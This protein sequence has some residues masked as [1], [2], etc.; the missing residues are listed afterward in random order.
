MKNNR[1]R[2]NAVL[3][4]VVFIVSILTSV[5]FIYN[6][7]NVSGKTLKNG[8]TLQIDKNSGISNESYTIGNNPTELLRENFKELTA[9]LKEEDPIKISEYVA[10]CFVIDYYTWTNKDGN[11]EVGGLQYIYGS[12]FSNFYDESRHNFYG[13][14]DLLISKYGHENLLEV[15]SISG[16]GVDGGYYEVNGQSYKNYYIEV[17]WEYKKSS[18]I[19]INDYQNVAYFN[20]IDNN[21]RYEIV[22]IMYPEDAKKGGESNV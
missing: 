5:A 12:S 16:Y 2:L 14:L 7:F 11:Y 20:I 4:L 18:K 15:S 19:D 21:G 10:K 22:S 13:D 3:V 6:I 17:E 9:A 1:K 8:D